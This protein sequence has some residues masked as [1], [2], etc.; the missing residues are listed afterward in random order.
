MS[1]TSA[2]KLVLKARTNSRLPTAR[3]FA[4]FPPSAVPATTRRAFGPGA[5]QST[6]G[7]RCPSSAFLIDPDPRGAFLRR[8]IQM[9]SATAPHI[10]SAAAGN[11]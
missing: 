7:E 1:A 10:A 11:L 4:R 3:K 5:L 6:Y 2:R 9:L 8:E